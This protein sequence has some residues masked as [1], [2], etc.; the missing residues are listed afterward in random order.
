MEQR[1]S[2]SRYILTALSIILVLTA[3]ILVALNAVQL[4]R[5]VSSGKSLRQSSSTDADGGGYIAGYKAA[6]E[7]YQ[8]LCPLPVTN[9]LTLSGVIQSVS[10]NT[11]VVLA[12]NLDT[13]PIVDGISDERTILLSAKTKIQK[14]T[15][16]TS[17]ELAQ[18]S[19]AGTFVEPFQ[20]TVLNASSLKVGQLVSIQSDSEVRFAAKITAITIT[21]Q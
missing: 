13:D 21:V 11:L 4:E 2:T 16:K 14:L 1:S 6:R 20:I 10:S 3:F 8:M 17:E 18:A 7:K 5:Y 19:N 12:K 15:P 9:S